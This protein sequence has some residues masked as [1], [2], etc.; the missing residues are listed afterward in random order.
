VLKSPAEYAD[1]AAPG[2]GAEEDVLEVGQY[3]SGGDHRSL[4]I[5]LCSGALGRS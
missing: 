4:A 5:R 3:Y 1:H 2:K